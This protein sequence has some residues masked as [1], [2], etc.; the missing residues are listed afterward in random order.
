MQIR[1]QFFYDPEVVYD[2]VRNKVE[3]TRA[4]GET[5]D[6]LSFVPDGEAT[7]DV[8]LGREI[9]L[10]RDLGIDIAVITNASIIDDPDV[11]NELARADVVSLKVDAVRE[12]AWRAVDRP[13]G[14]LRLDTILEG[15]L[16]F[17]KRYEGRLLTETLLVRGAN[18]GTDDVTATAEFVAKLKPETAFLSIPTRPPSEEWV[19][20]PDEE[21]MNRAYQIFADRCESVECLLGVEEGSFGYSGDVEE[22]ILGVTAVHPMPEASL[23]EL[24][25]KAGAEWSVVERLLADGQI[26]K[27]DYN[28]GA[29]YFRKLPK[30]KRELG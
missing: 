24:L 19:R 17:A 3:Q 1:R 27:I 23:R 5:I 13:H 9:D 4:K 16:E 10:L 11:Q 15:N 21:S 29:F 18:D 12:R 6:Y 28:D 14:R 25:D 22:D 7:L 2:V 20:G 8:N 30:V 26:V